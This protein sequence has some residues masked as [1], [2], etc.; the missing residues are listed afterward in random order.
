MVTTVIRAPTCTRNIAVTTALVSKMPVLINKL[1]DFNLDGVLALEH[2]RR[3]VLRGAAERG[4]HVE[5]RRRRVD[6]TSKVGQLEARLRT[7]AE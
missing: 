6:S 5:Q 7:S 4:A 1:F 2:L 3:E